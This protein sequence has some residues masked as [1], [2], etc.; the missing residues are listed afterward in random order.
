[1]SNL[2]SIFEE[3]T[4]QVF[5]QMKSQG[6]AHPTLLK[7]NCGFCELWVSI[8]IALAE[9]DESNDFHMCDNFEIET[10]ANQKRPPP[11]AWLFAYGKHYDAECL[12]GVVDYH[13]LPLF[14]RYS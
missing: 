4:Q 13:D 6:H 10:F 9:R 2:K 11:H 14:R 1:M 12:D 3:A 8:V 7:L 5:E